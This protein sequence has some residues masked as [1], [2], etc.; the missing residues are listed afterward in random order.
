MLDLPEID[1]E[2]SDLW[3]LRPDFAQ[4]RLYIRLLCA[5]PGW[6]WIRKWNGLRRQFGRQMRVSEDF[7]DIELQGVDYLRRDLIDYLER[8]G[9]GFPL[10]LNAINVAATQDSLHLEADDQSL[11]VRFAKG[12][13]RLTP[14]DPGKKLEPPQP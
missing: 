10:E 3:D 2:Y 5:R 6:Y 12:T 13:L 9:W 4:S 1:I 8:L 7:V 14:H 11:D